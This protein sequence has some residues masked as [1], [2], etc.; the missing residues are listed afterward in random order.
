MAD[1]ALELETRLHD[2][3]QT[4]YAL[5]RAT[6]AK[7]FKVTVDSLD[8]IYRRLCKEKPKPDE[9]EPW[10]DPVDGNGLLSALVHQIGRYVCAEPEEILAIALWV[11][12]AHAHDASDISPILL[13]SSPVKGCGKSTLLDVL[14]ILVPRPMLS[15]NCSAAALYRSIG[16]TE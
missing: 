3:G 11:I 9:P 10:P 4:Q 12:H 1:R 13:V 8:G 2:L 6:L 7:E 5:D 14:E 15:A 16:S